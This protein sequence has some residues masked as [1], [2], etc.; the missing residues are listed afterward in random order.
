MNRNNDN[1][2]YYIAAIIAAVF[3]L[4]GQSLS[5]DYLRYDDS[6]CIFQNEYT[7]G[8]ASC[9][10]VQY[11]IPGFIRQDVY[12]PLTFLLL[13]F[14]HMISGGAP[15]VFHLFSSVLYACCCITVFFFFKKLTAFASELKGFEKAFISK[16]A[17]RIY[18][19]DFLPFMAALIFAALPCH[20][21]NTAWISSIGYSPAV[22]AGL[23]SI[24]LFLSYMETKNISMYLSSAALFIVAVLFQQ[25]A[26]VIP[27]LIIICIACFRKNFLQEAVKAGAIYGSICAVYMSMFMR[28]TVWTSSSKP[29]S[30]AEKLGFQGR[31]LF[32][33][34]IP[35]DLMPGY[36]REQGTVFILIF[37]AILALAVYMIF[38]KKSRLWL[39]CSLWHAAALFPYSGIFFGKDICDRYLILPS[40][41]SSF[42]L[43]FHMLAFPLKAFRHRR[44]LRLAPAGLLLLF[45][46]AC[47]MIY[48]PVW[49]DSEAFFAYAYYKNPKAI[50]FSGVYGMD[51]LQKGMQAKALEISEAII[52]DGRDPYTGYSMKIQALCAMKKN[53]QALSACLEAMEKYPSL[54][55]INEYAG[56][57]CFMEGDYERAYSY[58]TKALSLYMK[59]NAGND[60]VRNAAV[61][62]LEAAFRAKDEEKII[63]LASMLFPDIPQEIKDSKTRTYENCSKFAEN[64]KDSASS[65][66]IMKVLELRQ[67]QKK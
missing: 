53:K 65:I 9:S 49:S 2:K 67:K 61:K 1:E 14:I 32:S 8:T 23:L 35:T 3:I 40:I 43:A 5:F 52:L 33:M 60:A 17:G 46:A 44:A 42:L 64:S 37:A 31:Y 29:L 21:E 59:D 22:I 25:A 24:M 4:Y 34:L 7:N 12:I 18:G 6:F 48:I 30:L 19:K 10:I 54:D 27:G 51:C 36:S 28:H 26:I 13:R 41:A 58:F 62:A 56:N 66:F 57:I 63:L 39:F 15:W 11:F 20:I 47:A 16:Y 45:Y 38:I 50:Q 55:A